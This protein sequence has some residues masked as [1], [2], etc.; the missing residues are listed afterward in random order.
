MDDYYLG[1][2]KKEKN[3]GYDSRDNENNKLLP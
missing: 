2:I 1:Y 3:I